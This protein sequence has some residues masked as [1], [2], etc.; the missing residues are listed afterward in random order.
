MAKILEHHTDEALRIKLADGRRLNLPGLVNEAE[1]LLLVPAEDRLALSSL[2][3]VIWHTSPG[4]RWSDGLYTAHRYWQN[5]GGS[6]GGR[7]ACEARVERD[8]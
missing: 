1:V 4:Y 5:N 3:T 7:E 8:R 6:D 2:A